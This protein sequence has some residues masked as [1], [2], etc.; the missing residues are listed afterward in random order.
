[1]ALMLGDEYRTQGYEL[2]LVDD[3]SQVNLSDW[4]DR[5]VCVIVDDIFQKA[6]SHMDV[7]R[8][9]HILYDLHLYLAKCKDRSE[10]RYE[11]MQQESGEEE[12]RDNQQLNL[13]QLETESDNPDLDAHIKTALSFVK[14]STRQD[15]AEAI[16]VS[17]GKKNTFDLL[18]SRNAD[19]NLTD[20]G[21]NSLLHVACQSDDTS[22][23]EYLLTRLDINRLGKHGWTPVMKAAVNGRK[24]VFDLLVKEKANLE[25]I[26]DSS[27]NLLHLACHGGNASIVKYL[28]PQ[29]NINSR[30]GNGWTPVMYAAVNGDSDVF[31]L[32]V[33]KDA[34]LSL[35]DDYNNSAFHLGCIGGNRTIVKDLLLKA[36]KNSQGNLGRTGI[37]KSAWAGNADVFKLLVSKKVDLKTVDDNNDTILHLAS[38]GGNCSIVEYLIEKQFDINCRGKN[39]LTTVMYA[40]LSGKKDAFELL[41]SKQDAMSAYNVYRDTIL[42]LAC[43][44]GT[45]SIVQSLLLII[46]VNIR[47]KND[48]TPVMAAAVAGKKDV[49][50]F[51]ISKK[52]DLTPTDDNKNNILHLACRGGNTFIIG[53]L[54]PLFDMNSPGEDGLTPLMM[55]ALS[56]K[57]EAYD[58]IARKGGNQSLTASENDIVLHAACLGGN[59][60]TVK[61]DNMGLTPVMTG[62]LHRKAAVVKYLT[63]RGTDLT[64]VDNTGDDALTLALKHGNRQIIKQLH[65]KQVQQVAPWSELM[66]SLVR[67]EVVFLKTYSRGSADL[68]QT[69]QD[70][71]SLL[72]LACRGGNR[73]CV[74]YLL[75]SY[76]VNVRGR[77]GWT[78]VMM[79]AACGHDEV[80]HLL[81]SHD[82][83]LTLVSDTGE[84]ILS[85]AQRGECSVAIT[86]LKRNALPSHSLRVE[87]WEGTPV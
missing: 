47:G 34:D 27:N 38:Q 25:L 81:V 52:A 50:D 29:F 69:D 54:I 75:P 2:V 40:A 46:D 65:R 22:I 17:S 20:D 35:E 9:T 18:L 23:L 56:G 76:D 59:L 71:D 13:S 78:P 55:G 21:N 3:L 16:R 53:H 77:Y 82:A 61:E 24:D 33:S 32:L 19:I 45:I 14:T 84:T 36:D 31:R 60:A 39:D 85:L 79:A 37:M 83:D 28:L 63:N 41:S 4:Q 15:V 64:L 11:S 74:E 57:K 70:G 49:F 80:I 26:D 12:R 5:D 66:K 58:L 8:L 43:E 72:H 30:G 7:P 68:V 42:H 87:V 44:G 48:R 6:R 51:L 67:G 1:M 86:I 62:V 10:R 73:W